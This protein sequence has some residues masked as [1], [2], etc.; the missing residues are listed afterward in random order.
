MVLGQLAAD[1]MHGLE[2]RVSNVMACSDRSIISNKSGNVVEVNDMTKRYESFISMVQSDKFG[3]IENS[4]IVVNFE[5]KFYFL[6]G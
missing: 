5:L 3:K 2:T 6:Y 4:R 1:N